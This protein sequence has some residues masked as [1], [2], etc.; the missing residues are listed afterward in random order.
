M[1]DK[2]RKHGK[3]RRYFLWR[4]IAIISSIALLL[5]V[6]VAVPIGITLSYYQSQSQL[7]SK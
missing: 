7:R 4:K 3:S 2:L 1:K 6:S 5:S